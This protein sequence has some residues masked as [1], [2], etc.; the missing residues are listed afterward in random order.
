MVYAFYNIKNTFLNGIDKSYID[1]CTQLYIVL[2][3]V[4]FI[5]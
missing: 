2:T 3:L 5:I 1:L 4:N